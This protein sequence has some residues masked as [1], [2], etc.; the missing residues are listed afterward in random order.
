MAAVDFRIEVP[1]AVLADLH[2]RL[3]RSR[4]SPPS[5]ERE[6]QAGTDPDYLRDLIA[7]WVD[8]YDWRQRE[9]E[10]NAPQHMAE[11]GGHRGGSVRETGHGRHTLRS[12]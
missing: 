2:S 9:G 12:A 8:R 10:L 7:Y 5:D 11:V 3:A 1:D 4:F 6:W